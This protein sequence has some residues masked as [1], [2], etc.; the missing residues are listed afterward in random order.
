MSV[1]D[2]VIKI[3]STNGH[4]CVVVDDEVELL[5][6]FRRMLEKVGF[7]VY[8][9]DDGA[10]AVKEHVCAPFDLAIIDWKMPKMHGYDV[11]VAMDEAPQELP[12]MV[13][14]TGNSDS[15]SVPVP[16]DAFL[17]KPFTSEELFAAVA[18]AFGKDV[19]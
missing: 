2:E 16:V 7:E 4:R 9:T 6:L 13:V 12:K 11:M 18:R 10:Q 5:G 15:L 1:I 14:M 3:T 17:F 8:V 19:G